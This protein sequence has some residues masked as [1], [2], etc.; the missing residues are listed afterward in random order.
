MSWQM[1]D[2]QEQHILLHNRQV[3]GLSSLMFYQFSLL[4]APKGEAEAT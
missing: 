1:K 2:E 4:G 3:H